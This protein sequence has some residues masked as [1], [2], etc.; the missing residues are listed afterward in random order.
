MLLSQVISVSSAA[1]LSRSD[2]LFMLL[3][4]RSFYSVIL[5]NFFGVQKVEKV[6]V[7][8]REVIFLWLRK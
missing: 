1:A 6:V 3:G 2:L 5:R 8:W 7:G 4:F